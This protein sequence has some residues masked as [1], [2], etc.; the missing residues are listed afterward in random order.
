MVG[1]CSRSI[2]LL[3]DYMNK[4]PEVT[5]FV[6]GWTSTIQFDLSGEDPFGLEFSRDGNIQ[7]KTG[8]LENPDVI[9]YCKADLF[10]QI[11]TGRADQDEAFSN[12]L[13]EV[14]GS[15]IDSVKFRHAAELTQ[16]NHST[17]FTTLRAFS[18]FV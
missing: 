4:T 3:A 14:R 10:F 1:K 2:S 11:L 7:F 6:S 18:R 9:F 8:R 5:K 13:V 17:L 16:E 15:I 12:G